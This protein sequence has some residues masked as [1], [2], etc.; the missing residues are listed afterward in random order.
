MVKPGGEELI[1]D[2]G[3]PGTSSAGAWRTFTGN[4]SYGDDYLFASKSSSRTYRWTATPPGINYEVYAWWVDKRNQSANVDYTIRY[5]TGETERVTMSQKAGGSQWQLL[6]EYYSTDGQDYVEVSSGSDKFVADAIRWV[7]VI[8]P[9]ITRTETTNFIHFDH[10]GTPRRVT[11]Q[12]QTVIWRWDSTPFGDSEPDQDPDGDSQAYVLNL[13]FPGQYYDVE[14]GLHYNY[15]R[16]YDP[17]SGR[18]IE[19]DPIGL[20]GG[21]NTFGYA[22]QRPQNSTDPF[23]L[24]VTG[25]WIEQPRFNFKNLGIDDFELV[26]GSG[27]LWGQLKFIRLF[28]H[29]T[30]FVNI[31]VKCKNSD[32]CG[33]SDWEIHNKIEVFY[34]GSTDVGVN[35]YAFAAGKALGFYGWAAANIL[36]TGGSVLTGGLEMLRTAQ[37]KAGVEIA[38]VYALGPDAICL[39]S[40]GE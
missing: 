1:L 30:G 26:G 5:G 19:S 13:R 33:K 29:V 34:Q 7:E 37:Q 40:G 9:V 2:D 8:D 39:A 10:L 15:F 18:Y 11:D 27:N 22:F 36:A 14:S 31:D 4:G 35:A 16:T 6:G 38:L 32:E 17:A 25:E 24:L 28:G 23:G 21:L 12:D 3:D 20:R